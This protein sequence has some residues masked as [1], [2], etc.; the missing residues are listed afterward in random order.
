MLV[1]LRIRFHQYPYLLYHDY[2]SVIEGFSLELWH[3]I[4]RPRIKFQK[5]GYVLNC[6]ILREMFAV[7]DIVLGG[8]IAK[9][10][11]SFHCQIAVDT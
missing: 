8:A 2:V 7:N 3:L 9:K 5:S 6:V 11:Y 4:S 10:S 1:Q